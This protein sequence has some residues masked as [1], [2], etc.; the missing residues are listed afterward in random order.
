MYVENQK[1][2]ADICDWLE[3]RKIDP[4]AQMGLYTQHAIINIANGLVKRWN[5]R[6]YTWTDEMSLDA[7]EVCVRYLHNYDPK[8]KNA[9]AYITKTC[10]SA[11]VN[12]IKK[13]NKQIRAKYRYYLHAVPD[14]EE[15]DEDG[16]QI[17]VDYSFFKDIGDK[18]KEPAGKKVVEEEVDEDAGLMQFMD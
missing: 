14:I 9:H 3:R 7:I 12:R 8:Y 2:Y 16:N 4:T 5:F 1:L 10:F 6:E 11:C 17:H 18:L 13:E 15:Y